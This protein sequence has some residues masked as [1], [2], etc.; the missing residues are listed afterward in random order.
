MHCWLCVSG[1]F[2]GT[3]VCI[4]AGFVFGR[5]FTVESVHQPV[6]VVPVDP[7]ADDQFQIGEQSASR[8]GPVFLD[9]VLTRTLVFWTACCMRG[10]SCQGAREIGRCLQ[11]P[12]VY[13]AAMA[14][15]PWQEAATGDIRPGW[16]ARVV[17]RPQIIGVVGW[18]LMILFGLMLLTTLTL[19]DRVPAIL[20]VCIALFGLAGMVITLRYRVWIDDPYLIVR[21]RWNRFKTIRLDSLTSAEISGVTAPGRTRDVVLL[22]STGAQLRLQPLLINLARLYAE[23]NTYIDPDE[24]GGASVGAEMRSIIHR[25]TQSAH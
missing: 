12:P 11:V 13:C 8:A 16:D 20:G 23:L 2:V 7:G 4:V 1:G 5:W 22:D 17:G 19:G 18:G 6:V 10:A 3:V 9:S 21:F 24:P 15:G 14:H 25:H